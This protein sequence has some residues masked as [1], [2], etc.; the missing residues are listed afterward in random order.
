MDT[1]LVLFV[2]IGVVV[3]GFVGRLILLSGRRYLGTSAPSSG[4]AATM[5]AV[6][7][8]LVALGMVA[9]FAVIPVGDN[10]PQRFLIRMGLLLI[11]L[12]VIFGIVLVLLSRKREE[13][14]AAEV[15]EIAGHD[16]DSRFDV[17]VEPVQVRGEQ[18]A[19]GWSAEAG[20]AMGQPENEQ[21]L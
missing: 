10:L 13:A 2:V 6:L 17:T 12:A 11:M 16:H 19:R 20:T 8:H 9:L 1:E 14:M 4:S 7:F 3:V 18:P 5:I 21:S 15:I